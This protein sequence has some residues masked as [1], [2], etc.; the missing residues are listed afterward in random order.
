MQKPYLPLRDFKLPHLMEASTG[1]TTEICGNPDLPFGIVLFLHQSNDYIKRKLQVWR[2]QK[3][4]S[5]SRCKNRTYLFGTSNYPS[6][7][8]Q[9]RAENGNL[10]KSW[11]TFR[12]GTVFPPKQCLNQKKATGME[13]PKMHLS[14]RCRNRTYLCGT[15]NYHVSCN[16]VQDRERKFAEIQFYHSPWYCTVFTPKQCLYQKEATGIESP[17]MHSSS[18]CKNRTYLCGTSNYP[19]SC[20]PVQS[21]EWKFAEIRVYLSP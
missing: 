3:M 14:S 15:S 11:S 17:K 12:H 9:Y 8:T 19:V 4:H 7:E 6:D 10:K 16:Q 13:S 18:R 20:N 2:I 5:S 1:P 21:R